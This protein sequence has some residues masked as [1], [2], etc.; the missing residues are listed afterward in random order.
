[1]AGLGTQVATQVPSFCCNLQA[2]SGNDAGAAAGYKPSFSMSTKRSAEPSLSR[3]LR[4]GSSITQA[5]STSSAFTFS[6]HD[7]RHLR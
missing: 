7:P 5:H 4:S 1:M 6:A 3:P 2:R